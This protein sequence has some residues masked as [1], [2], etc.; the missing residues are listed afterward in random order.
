MQSRFPMHALSDREWDQIL[1]ALPRPLRARA[2][3]RSRFYRNFVEA[4]LWVTSTNSLWSEL[5]D[6]FGPWRAIYVR[7]LRWNLAGLWES[8]EDAIGPQTPAA[9]G[10][11]LRTTQHLA[12]VSRRRRKAQ[13]DASRT[14]NPQEQAPTLKLT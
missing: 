13:R 6:R 3:N 5:P 8:V 12:L 9:Q 2:G 4:V 14:T 7:F 10:L 11:R 1:S